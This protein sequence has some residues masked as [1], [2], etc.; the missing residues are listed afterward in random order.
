[1]K[2]LRVKKFPL[3][4]VFTGEGWDHWSR[5][6]RQGDNVKVIAGEQ[7]NATEKFYLNQTLK[8][9]ED[10]ERRTS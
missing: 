2:I 8:G 4:D 5:V 6:V 1:M 7:L 10:A 9:R 3:Y